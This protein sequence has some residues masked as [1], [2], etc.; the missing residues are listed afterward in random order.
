MNP[1]RVGLIGYGLAG[2]TFHAPF[3][4]TSLDYD[5]VA[6]VSSNSDKVLQDFP[7]ASIYPSVEALAEGA[8]V[9]LGVIATPNRLHY[10]QALQCLESRMHV[11][12]DKPF[13][14]TTGEASALMRAASEN[15]RIL[16]VYHNRRWDSDFLAMRR[17]IEE[18]WVGTPRLCHIR[19]DRFRPQIRDRW[20]ERAE[21]GSGTLYDLGSHLLDQ[22]ISL[23]GEPIYIS[24]DLGHQRPKA[25]TIDF[26]HL[27]LDY[28]EGLRVFLSSSSYVAAETPHFELHGENGSFVTYGMDPQEDRLRDGE[29]PADPGF[30]RESESCR[31]FLSRPSQVSAGTIRIPLAGGSYTAYYEQLARSIR[32]DAPVPVAPEAALFVVKAIEKAYASHELGGCRVSWNEA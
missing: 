28:P 24:A 21:P 31:G 5:V 1:I 9:D 11:V 13:T 22:A 15:N 2:K 14:L 7:A 23:F 10:Q 16:S 12:V 29:S 27:R 30:I 18:S 6:V 3:L 32:S 19:F 8:D 4:K 26:S 17:C 25:Q 20:R